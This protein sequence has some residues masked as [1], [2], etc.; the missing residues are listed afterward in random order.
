MQILSIRPAPAGAG[1]RTVAR[2]DV[3]VS[4][5]VRLHNLK[6]VDGQNGRRVYAA[7]AFGANTATFTTELARELVRLA[8][9]ALGEISYNGSPSKARD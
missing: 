3:E 9:Q 1:G 6:L 7:S 4:P 8:T 5:D 2:F